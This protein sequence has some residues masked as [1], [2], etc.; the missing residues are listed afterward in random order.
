MARW[1]IIIALLVVIGVLSLISSGMFHLAG[2]TY[3]QINKAGVFSGF[4]H[5]ILAPITLVLGLFT[6]IQMYELNNVGWWYN[7]GFLIG[8]MAVWAGGKT[9]QHVTKNYYYGEKNRDG[10]TSEDKRDIESLIDKKMRE[11][12]GKGVKVKKKDW[13]FWEW[14]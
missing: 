2:E 1:G 3:F 5:G 8:L 10:L 9:T 11:K 7:C 13:K 4:I 12:K 6:K 14:E